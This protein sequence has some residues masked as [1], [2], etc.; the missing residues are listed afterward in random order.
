MVE[1]KR[2]EGKASGRRHRT[3][4]QLLTTPVQVVTDTFDPLLKLNVV[5]G[6]NYSH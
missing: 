1:W 6:L 2:M 5:P 4:L 3:Y